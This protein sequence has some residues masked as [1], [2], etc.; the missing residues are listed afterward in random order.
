M[1]GDFMLNGGSILRHLAMMDGDV[2]KHE[3]G[4]PLSVAGERRVALLFD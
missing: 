1:S 3:C 2:L 4:Q